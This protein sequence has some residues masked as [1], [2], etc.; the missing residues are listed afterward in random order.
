MGNMA[1]T[2]GHIIDSPNSSGTFRELSE[3][4]AGS[5]GV[6]QRNRLAT[7]GLLLITLVVFTA[8]GADLIITQDPYEM[9]IIERLSGPSTQH[10][11]GT[12]VFGRDIFTR[13]VLGTR[14]AMQVAMGAVLLAVI[15][16]VPL[17]AFS[18]YM[19]GR[20]DTLIMRFIDA[21]LAFPGRLLAIA[22]VA[23]MGANFLTL[24]LAIGITSIPGY[25]RV[26]RGVVLSQK[27]KEYVE[28]ARMT[29]ESEFRILFFQI[30]PNC[31]GPILV[32]ITLDCAHAITTESSLSFLGLGFAPPSPSWGLMLNEARGY[33]ELGPHVALIPG[34]A[35]SLTILGFNL[36]GDGLRDVFDPRQYD[37]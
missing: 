35:I 37:K 20:V 33:M 5:L 36:L 9:N 18:G 7:V 4:I 19:G 21:V 29:G 12:D 24:W 2:T 23:A 1:D 11:F 27:E 14:I 34:L 3:K 10:L 8:L 26:V 30:I 17:G 6:I 16:G 22:M 15:I 13:V 31:I 32:L 25:A 28:A